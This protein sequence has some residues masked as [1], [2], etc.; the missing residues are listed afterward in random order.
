MSALRS[1]TLSNFVFTLQTKMQMLFFEEH[2]HLLLREESVERGEGE[3]CVEV[4]RN[5][6]IEM[7]V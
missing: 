5:V 6:E 1:C 3:E 7:I 2:L 4:E